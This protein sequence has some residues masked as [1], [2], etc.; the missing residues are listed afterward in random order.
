M[1][2]RRAD[3]SGSVFTTTSGK[4][5]V[6]I[7]V[8]AKRPGFTLP[9]C[10]LR[11][12]AAARAKLM[13]DWARRMHMAGHV[14]QLAPMLKDA[15]EATT[16]ERLDMIEA[17][18]AKLEARPA[19]VRPIASDS[20]TFAQF[21]QAWIKG[22]LNRRWPDHVR[23][24]RDP[25]GPLGV[26]RNHVPP[27]VGATP[28]AAFT[29]DHADAI[30]SALPSKMAP[31]TRLRVAKT[32]HHV[33]ALAVYPARLLPANAIPS[34]WLPK[35]K[36]APAKGF[37]YPEE[38]AALMA[39]PEASLE[40]RVFWGMLA[41]EGMRTSEA[42]GLQW[43]DLD[44]KRGAVRLDK[45]KTNA[46]RT[47]VLDPGVARA[48]AAWHDRCGAPEE[49]SVF[50]NEP[51]WHPVERF[52]AKLRK[53]GV[54]RQELFE[55]TPDRRRI[56]VHDLRATFVTVSLAN[57][58]T[59][60]WVADRTGHRSSDMINRYRRQARTWAE[61]GLGTLAPLDGAIPELRRGDQLSREL[62]RA[63]QKPRNMAFS[64]EE[65]L[66]PRS[67]S[68]TRADAGA[69]GSRAPRRSCAES[70]RPEGR[71]GTRRLP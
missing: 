34:G 36:H 27:H 32:I 29:L 71:A 39:C 14:A 6:R 13:T 2:E 65:P 46:P 52:L 16:R 21:A 57:G 17:A 69:T 5:S 49:G 60:A 55:S 59:E 67:T 37:L 9:W 56:R 64:K 48:L 23:P 8:G 54:K 28:I 30:M 33:L 7:T 11:A 18:V 43:P 3:G 66:T 24:L 31:G 63:P 61:L 15:A 26:L 40:D 25:S 22:E 41:R 42:T 62:S 51:G 44:L 50:P 20:P 68:R 35:S 10:K 47:W 4:L 1:A 38:D 19:P 53:A 12:Q 58:K 45:N 70:T